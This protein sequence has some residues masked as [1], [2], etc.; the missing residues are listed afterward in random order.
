[1][2]GSFKLTGRP[3]NPNNISEEF[4]QRLMLNKVADTMYIPKS[5]KNN[6]LIF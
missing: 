3:A 5:S 6:L 4:H 2:L 1:M